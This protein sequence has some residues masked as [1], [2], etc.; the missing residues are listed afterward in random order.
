MLQALLITFR[1]GIESFLIVGIISTYL[2]KTHRGGLLRGV[3]IGL[4]ASVVT[5]LAGAWLWQRVPN[6]PLYEGIG[7]LV[8][9]LFVGVLLW[10]AV[11]TGRR[12][13]GEIE[14]RVGRFAGAEGG[15]PQVR[16][17]LG[18]AF[19]TMLL[20]TREGLEAVFYLGVQ[21]FAVKASDV[22][23]GA[24]LGFVLAAG[25]AWGW[26]R[27]GHRL[28]LGIVLKV[29]SIFLTLFLLQLVVYGIHELAESGVIEGSQAF[30]NA[31]EIFGP[32][33]RMGHLLSYSL[34]GAPLLYAF[35]AWRAKR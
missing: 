7:A 4:L 35:W 17:I 9:A 8:A 1:E 30:H 11:R 34:L 3:R 13:K 16:A 5:C 19:V 15:P 32:D 31:T 2:R 24:A 25:I 33:G 14:Q 10:Q 6:Q 26:S 12:I 23:L 27:F 18:V 22:V 28:N 29:T 21:A 20:V